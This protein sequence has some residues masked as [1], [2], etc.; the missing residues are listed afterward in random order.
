VGGAGRQV[1][2]IYHRPDFESW[3]ADLGRPGDLTLFIGADDEW[4]LWT[5]SGYYT[6]NAPRNRRFGYCVD[7]G[8]RQ[9]ALFFPA[10]RFAHL[11]RPDIVAAVV[12][13][14]T[15]AR[16]RASGVPIPDIDLGTLLPPIVEL[17][18]SVVADGRD[19][20]SLSFTVQALR[21][22]RPATRVW[23]L[24]NGRFAWTEPQPPTA[25]FSRHRVTLP[26]RPGRNVLA[27]H[28]ESEASK[29]VPVMLEVEGPAGV[30]QEA[31]S[32][33][34]YLLSVGVSN[35]QIAG[36][37]QAG[38]TQALQF[39][40]RDATAV[41]NALA[42]SR[43]SGRF[44]AGM[45]LQNTAFDAVEATLLVDAAATKAAILAQIERLAALIEQRHLEAGAERDVLFVF[46]SGHGTRFKGEPALY[47]WNWDLIPTS[48]DMERTG[49]S[50]VEFASIATAVPAE[51]VLVIDACH[52]GMAGNNMMRGLDPEE[53]ARR[54]QAINE[55]GMYIIN[56][57]RSEELSFES[58]SLRHGVLTRALLEALHSE[59][60]ASRP[61]RKV[62]MLNLMAGV[63]ELVP[64]LGAR[65]GMEP[66]TPVCRSYGDLLQ[67]AIYRQPPR[68][69]TKA[70]PA[71]H[72]GAASAN[73]AALR[74]ETQ[75]GRTVPMVT[76]KTPA[77]KAATKPAPAKKAP[78][79]KAAA[80]A[81]IKKVA[82]KKA[83]PV[84]V[85]AP[86]TPAK[87]APA[88]KAPAKKVPAK[89]AVPAKKAPVKKVA[90]KT[91]L[92][93]GGAKPGMDVVR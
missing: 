3:Q 46:L 1:M 41:Y 66:Q 45:A 28:A 20:V 91:A 10:D 35:F 24:R 85:A 8:P 23:V 39:A 56:A 63:Q 58:E 71:L 65:A 12:E 37:E 50:L 25:A 70:S 2:Q 79:T 9:E 43:R 4:V 11:D 32:G 42:G 33:N 67:L 47:F 55:R 93:R 40:H 88:K 54:I 60:F 64:R 44:D 6:T 83:A 16:A 86:K 74:N 22:E 19:T 48:A 87:K 38:S 17:E 53:L 76:Q 68:Q 77:K 62:S 73:V 81:P 31:S 49:L 30:Q 84:K 34:L 13:H 90:A 29:S 69:H 5:R 57:A 75:P 7:R 82:A 27:I 51:V 26:L 36:T 78:A 89:N 14:G 72:R 52:S 59:R 80:T 21:P 18:R 92:K 61:G 15:E